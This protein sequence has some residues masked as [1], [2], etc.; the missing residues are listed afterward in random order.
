MRIASARPPSAYATRAGKRMRSARAQAHAPLER[1]CV[2]A[3]LHE[4]WARAQGCSVAR[5]RFRAGSLSAGVSLPRSQRAAAMRRVHLGAQLGARSGAPGAPRVSRSGAPPAAWRATVRGPRG[6]CA[7]RSSLG[8][9]AG[10]RCGSRRRGGR[11]GHRRGG[12]AARRGR[13][14]GRLLGGGAP[15]ARDDPEVEILELIAHGTSQA[16]EVRPA[17]LDAELLEGAGR[18]VA[19]CG[20]LTGVEQDG[21]EHL[22]SKTC[23]ARPALEWDKRRERELR[24]NHGI[25]HRCKCPADTSLSSSPPRLL[26]SQR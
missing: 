24:G 21:H 22:E 17:A 19:V 3:D 15:A 8:S 11:P 25:D 13:G 26:E 14:G 4:R 2:R 6:W 18:E 10:G 7:S 1:C 5:A 12:R 9:A 16:E 23:R 20:G